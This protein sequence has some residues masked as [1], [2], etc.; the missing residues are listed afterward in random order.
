[1]YR[2]VGFVQE[3]VILGV[4]PDIQVSVA[5]IGA[6]DALVTAVFMMIG[7]LI[8]SAGEKT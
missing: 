7:R 5:R 4:V 3:I 1:V 8:G 6:I 2:A